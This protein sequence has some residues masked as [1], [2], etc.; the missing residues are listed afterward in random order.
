MPDG[1]IPPRL[2]VVDDDP[3]VADAL[4]LGLGAHGWSCSLAMG[5]DDAVRRAQLERP[6]L[7]VMDLAMPGGDGLTATAALKASP[8]TAHIPVVL[9]TGH[10]SGELE[11]LAHRAGCAR[12]V[13]KPLAPAALHTALQTELHGAARSVG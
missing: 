6:D 4:V 1:P 8:L 13:A 3:D 9:F 2:L 11:V 12:I 5:G 7:I 10:V